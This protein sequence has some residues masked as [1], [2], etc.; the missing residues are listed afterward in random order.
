MDVPFHSAGN[1]SVKCIVFNHLRLGISFLLVSALVF[2]AGSSVGSTTIARSNSFLSIAFGST[3]RPPGKTGNPR[4]LQWR[5]TI[6]F[7]LELCYTGGAH[8]EPVYR[9]GY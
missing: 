3:S 7:L 8:K 2:P 4:F 5:G 9:C 1:F 6:P